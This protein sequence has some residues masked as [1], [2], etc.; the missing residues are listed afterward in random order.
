MAAWFKLPDLIR[1]SAVSRK[2]KMFFLQSSL[3]S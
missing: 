2:M 3:P 1:V